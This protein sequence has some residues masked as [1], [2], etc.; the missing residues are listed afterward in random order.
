MTGCSLY[1]SAEI[2]RFLGAASSALRWTWRL[3]DDPELIG[4]VAYLQA[5]GADLVANPFGAITS[6]AVAVRI[7]P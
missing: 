6:N 3:P 2:D 5:V 4:V 1:T 7:L